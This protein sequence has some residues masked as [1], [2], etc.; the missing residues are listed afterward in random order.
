MQIPN[1]YFCGVIPAVPSA[2][3]LLWVALEGLGSGCSVVSCP[4]RH[5]LSPLWLLPT[6]D[7]VPDAPA[8]G[9]ERSL[10]V[11]LLGRAV[12]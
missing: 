1:L 10:P 5:L 7:E 4:P 6:G 2:P 11:T 9:G 12:P 8:G 3:W